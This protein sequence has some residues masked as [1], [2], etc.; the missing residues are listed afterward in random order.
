M[1]FGKAIH[2]IGASAAWTLVVAGL[3]K[4]TDIRGAMAP[5]RRLLPRKPVFVTGATLATAE[6]VIGGA[7]VAGL[8]LNIHVLL[9]PAA[10]WYLAMAI[11][12]ARPLARREAF[13]C[14]CFGTASG[15]RTT[16]WSVAFD[17]LAGAT[18]AG[19]TVSTSH[20][21]RSDEFRVCVGVA[22]ALVATSLLLANW[23]RVRRMN[24]LPFLPQVTR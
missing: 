18:L 19:A 7:A 5:L 23:R 24:L 22:P 1:A 15:K 4:S 13:S 6:I 2:S 8:A 12:L 10:F 3:L 21:S 17:V 14:N 16:W 11:L 20:W 9:I